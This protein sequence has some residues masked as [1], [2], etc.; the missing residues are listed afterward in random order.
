MRATLFAMLVLAT[1]LAPPAAAEPPRVVASIKPLHSLVAA[2]M[3]GVGAPTLLVP[4]NASPHVYSLKPSDAKQLDGAGLVFWI[5]PTYEAFLTKPLV[6][7]ARKAR[8]VTIAE[9]QG[10][11]VLHARTGGV[12]ADHAHGHDQGHKHKPG[13]SHDEDDGHLWLDPAN[14]KAIVT[15][16]ATALAAADPANAARY[17]ANAARAT[18]NLDAL[19]ARLAALLAPAKGQ[20][21]IVFHDAYQYLER[22]Y[23]LAA[24]GSVTVS[25][26]QKPGARRVKEIRE[27]IQKAGAVCIFAEPQFEPALVRT[28]AADTGARPGVLDPLG[29][30]VPEG[31]GHYPAMMEKLATSLATCL[32]A[33]RS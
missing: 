16:V 17:T 26:E 13:R 27:R 6:A 14:G 8:V 1:L 7:V 19:D 2:V 25:P 4:G 22:R 11:T 30:D 20:P 3:E 21:F 24:A 32:A 10:V 18:Q 33:P 9:A 5:G 15:A 29:A 28:I 12:W 31:P 23:G